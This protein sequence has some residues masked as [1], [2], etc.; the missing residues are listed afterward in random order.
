MKKGI[1]ALLVMLL[2]IAL[3]AP[4]AMAQD[5][6]AQTGEKQLTLQEAY[7]LA[8]KN[9]RTLKETKLSVDRA[10]EVK[11]FRQESVSFV[12]QSATSPEATSVFI[13]A[14]MAD[15]AYQMTVKGKQVNED[16][17]Y[18]LVVQAY[19]DLLT[20]Q[21]NLNY[22]KNLND[23]ANLH[24]KINNLSLALGMTSSIDYAI[25]YSDYETAQVSLQNAQTALE[26]DYTR[27]NNLLGIDVNERPI[28]LD[29]PEYE[30]VVVDHLDN[31]ISRTLSQ[32]PS[33]W[34]AEQ[35]VHLANLELELYNFLDPMREPY[36][37]ELIDVETEELLA[38]DTRS[39]MKHLLRSLYNAIQQAEELYK[40]NEQAVNSKEQN[41]HMKKLQYEVGM[42]S[43]IELAA[44]ELEVSK[45]QMELNKSIYQHNYLTMALQKPWA[46]VNSMSVQVSP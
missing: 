9:S 8:A 23:N 35:K 24:N 43:K 12:P 38:A 41:L 4:A 39:N 2:F 26:K 1:A 18:L 42:I 7:E 30:P 6:N 15:T 22:Y 31:Y 11:E 36:K 40:I 37:A 3:L 27:F 33:I 29:L 5:I 19:N 34:M 25:Q 44:A 10:R 13:A 17:L 16:T 45:A 32:D 20:A 21:E 46:Y 28:L 14:T